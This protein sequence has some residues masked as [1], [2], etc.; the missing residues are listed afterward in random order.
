[1]A[2]NPAL[3]FRDDISAKL[4]AVEPLPPESFFTEINLMNRIELLSSSYY[5]HNYYLGNHLQ[6]ISKNLDLYL[7]NHENIAMPEDVNAGVGENLVSTFCERYDMSNLINDYTCYENS[8]NHTCIDFTLN[9][10]RCSFQN[11][12]VI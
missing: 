10:S 8:K 6:I 5:P 12:C 2:S 1:M 9:N 11:S 4:Q 3:Y 7:S